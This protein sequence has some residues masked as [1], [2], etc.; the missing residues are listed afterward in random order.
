MPV[1]DE[2]RCSVPMS[3]IPR[4]EDGDHSTS[5]CDFSAISTLYWN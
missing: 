2:W 1:S 3:G 5:P 4:A